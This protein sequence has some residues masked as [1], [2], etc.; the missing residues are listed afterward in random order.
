MLSFL[1][2]SNMRAGPILNIIAAYSVLQTAKLLP[3]H[4]LSWNFSLT[5]NQ[6][7]LSL[8]DRAAPPD[9][10]DLYIGITQDPHVRSFLHVKIK[11]RKLNQ[12]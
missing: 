6:A 2:L 1:T 7:N 8:Q 5:K 4:A 11:L 9:H 3:H 12:N 10:V